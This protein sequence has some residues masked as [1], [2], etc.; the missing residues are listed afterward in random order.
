W[1]AA[2]GRTI[3]EMSAIDFGR[4]IRKVLRVAERVPEAQIIVITGWNKSYYCDRSVW[5]TPGVELVR[6]CVRDIAEGIDGTGVRAGIMKGGTGYNTFHEQDQKLMRVA[7]LVQRET[8][9]PVITHTEAGTLGWEQVRFLAEH[10]VPPERVCLSHM[11]R[12]PD[13]WEHRR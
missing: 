7:A 2:G 10:G 12:N 6:R 9:V 8:G 3:I 5:E 13:F 4:S 11:D 1:V